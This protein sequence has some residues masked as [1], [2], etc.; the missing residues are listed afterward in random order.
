MSRELHDDGKNIC[1]INGRIVNVSA[2][3]NIGKYLVDLHGQHNNQALLDSNT[4]IDILDKFAHEEITE[5]YNEYKTHYM[6]MQSLKSELNEIER[7]IAEKERK[8]DILNFEINEIKSVNPKNGEDDELKKKK[9]IID[10]YK[11]L[12]ESVAKAYYCLYDDNDGQSA[13]QT[14]TNSAIALSEARCIDDSL[15]AISESIEETAIQIQEISRMLSSY[16][17]NLENNFDVDFD[18]DAR[19]DELYK[20]KRKYGGTI[21]SV[22]DYLDKC[23]QELLSINTSEERYNEV[24]SA[25]NKVTENAEKT[26]LLLSEKRKQTARK[27]EKEICDSLMFLNMKDAVF[28]VSIVED[29]L[30][31]TG[32]DKVEFMLKTIV[33]AP[34]RPLNKIASGG[35][36]SR[37]MLAIKSVLAETD[38][39][40]TMIFDEIDTGVSGIAAQK[41]G[42]KIKNLSNEKQIFC[43]THL[44]Q[45]ASK[46]DTHFVIEKQSLNK[47]TN[48]NVTLLDDNGRINE[49]AR[50]ISGDKIT[51]TTI[52]QAKEMLGI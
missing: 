37:I 4:H 32:C 13:Y 44:A 24:L 8:T 43:V 40:K 49:I 3:K 12:L 26:A 25:L 2:L 42:E 45:I 23:E 20:I 17:D 10:N 47:K 46:A 16:L 28:E 48:A 31:K 5:I 22:L 51:Q 21:E 52:N 15:N 39:V 7:N 41:I 6:Q 34:L 27:I 38:S 29:K 33:G 19:L 1:R 18:I 36:L 11:K 35:E 30:T 14:I 9:E 50:I